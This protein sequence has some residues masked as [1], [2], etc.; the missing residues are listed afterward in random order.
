MIITMTITMLIHC[1]HTCHMR[2]SLSLLIPW[3]ICETE[4]TLTNKIFCARTVTQAITRGSDHV[5]LVVEVQYVLMISTYWMILARDIFVRVRNNYFTWY[6]VS[7][8][9]LYRI[10]VSYSHILY[11]DHVSYIL[12]MLFQQHVTVWMNWKIYFLTTSIGLP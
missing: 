3:N 12:Q 10:S 4:F 11:F 2:R 9:L 7:N 6:I 1:T 8:Q 5:K